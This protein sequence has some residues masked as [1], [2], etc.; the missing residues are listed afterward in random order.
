MNVRGRCMLMMDGDNNS[1]RLLVRESTGSRCNRSLLLLLV[2]YIIYVLAL[3]MTA[4]ALGLLADLQ[5]YIGYPN[6]DRCFLYINFVNKTNY[7]IDAGNRPSCIV[8]LLFAS[9]ATVCLIMLAILGLVK[10]T[11]RLK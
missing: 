4:I 6:L 11:L 5:S 7:T 9:I 2:Q 3:I 8:S 1:Q 10:L